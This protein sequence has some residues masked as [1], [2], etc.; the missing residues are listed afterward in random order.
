MPTRTYRS[1]TPRLMLAGAALAL[2]AATLAALVLLPAASDGDAVTSS[3]TIVSVERVAAPPQSA[4]GARA[5]S[6]D[7][8]SDL[9]GS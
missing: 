6:V 1:T 3:V 7:V 5:A 9:R 2:A 8:H 4:N